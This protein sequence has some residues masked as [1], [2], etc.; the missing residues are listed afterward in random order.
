MTRL[1]LGKVLCRIGPRTIFNERIRYS[2]RTICNRDR[3][4]GHRRK[5]IR[6]TEVH[7]LGNFYLVRT[8]IIIY[9]AFNNNI[10]TG[11]IEVHTDDFRTGTNEQHYDEE[12]NYF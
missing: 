9:D 7:R 2:G 11:I 1:P 10:W 12:E 3:S 8:R 4:T 6:V 5:N